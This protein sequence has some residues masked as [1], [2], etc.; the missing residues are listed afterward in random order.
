MSRPKYWW[1]SNVVRA[2]RQYKK[3]LRE[4]SIQNVLSHMAIE[5]ALEECQ[6]KENGQERLKIIT[7]LYINSSH[8]VSGVAMACYL[9]ESTVKRYAKEFVYDVARRMGYM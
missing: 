8:N 4:N 5:E 2:L 7:M 1:Y 3:G 6:Y 9:S